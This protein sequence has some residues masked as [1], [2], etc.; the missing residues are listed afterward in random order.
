M[1][2]FLASMACLSLV[3]SFV[4]E[5]FDLFISQFSMIFSQGFL[6]NLCSSHNL[7]NAHSVSLFAF[8]LVSICALH[9]AYQSF[10]ALCPIAFLSF[11]YQNSSACFSPNFLILSACSYSTLLN[12]SLSSSSNPS[13]EWFIQTADSFSEKD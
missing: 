13:S 5:Y 10:K 7:L 6:D 9:F 12:N 4:P 8:F 1:S 3:T 2:P 11:F